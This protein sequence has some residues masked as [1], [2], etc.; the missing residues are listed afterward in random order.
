MNS[1]KTDS[2]FLMIAKTMHG[3]EGVLAKELENL[4]AKNIKKIGNL[5]FSQSIS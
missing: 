4:G 2:Y 5:K 3:S 1:E